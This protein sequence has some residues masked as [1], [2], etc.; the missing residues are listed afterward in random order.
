MNFYYDV[1]TSKGTCTCT[2]GVTGYPSGAPCKHQDAIAS[3]YKLPRFNVLPRTSCEGRHFYAV[4]A[5]GQ[6]KAGEKSFYTDIHSCVTETATD[7]KPPLVHHDTPGILNGS[8][9]ELGTEE[10]VSMYT[11]LVQL[12]ERYDDDVQGRIQ[13]G[14]SQYPTGLLRFLRR[15]LE[16]VEHC[17]PGTSATP[18]LAAFFHTLAS[19]ERKGKEHMLRLGG[20]KLIT[21]QPTVRQRR[22]LSLS[23]RIQKAPQGTPTSIHSKGIQSLPKQGK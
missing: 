9:H 12:K 7:I 18:S 17:E 4:L 15:Y 23:S 8:D 20:S 10:V 21:T 6:E 16:I 19:K 22:R 2:I 1:D 5:V 13:Q 14:D 11:E 3:K